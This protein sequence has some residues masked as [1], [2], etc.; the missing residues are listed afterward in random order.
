M[1]TVLASDGNGKPP[2]KCLKF[3]TLEN[4]SSITKEDISIPGNQLKAVYM[5]K[6][7]VADNS[8][9]FCAETD[10]TGETL[11][12][13]EEGETFIKC[14][15]TDTCAYTDGKKTFRVG[16]GCGYNAEGQGYCKFP[17]GRKKEKWIQRL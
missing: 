15:K 3:G 17:S 6:I 4:L 7:G 9:S 10:Y 11:S 14:N 16:C 2:K 13:L 8:N 5:C 12:Q 1:V